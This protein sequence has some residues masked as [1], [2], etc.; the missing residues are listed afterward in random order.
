MVTPE[1]IHTS[2]TKLTEMVIFMYLGACVCNTITI[3]GKAT[4][5]LRGNMGG[6]LYLAREGI[7]EEL[8]E[9]NEKELCY[10]Y[11]FNYF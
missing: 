6:I 3:K 1:L 8:E 4:M 2:Y 9:G 7:R 10:I 5:I 11:I